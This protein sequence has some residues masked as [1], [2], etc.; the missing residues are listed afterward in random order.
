MFPCSSVCMLLPGLSSIKVPHILCF[1]SFACLGLVLQI[2]WH[3]DVPWKTVSFIVINE[4]SMYTY[5]LP[6]WH[7]GAL[8]KLHTFFKFMLATQICNIITL[9]YILAGLHLFLVFSCYYY[10]I[11]LTLKSGYKLLLLW[12]SQPP[13]LVS[14]RAEPTFICHG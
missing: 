7:K 1:Y 13:H 10:G 4:S 5:L 9:V 14:R 8:F 3:V 2:I 6:A 12:L 11:L